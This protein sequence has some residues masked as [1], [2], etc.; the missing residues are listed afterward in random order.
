MDLLV[1]APHALTMAG[2]GVGYRS[3]VAVAIDRGRIVALGPA[4]EITAEFTAERDITANH[5]VLL[6]GFVD[7][8][9]HSALCLLRGLA[10]DTRH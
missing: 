4:S 5:H 8:H 10:Q 2:D 6:P 7:A 3:D 9:M 1:Y